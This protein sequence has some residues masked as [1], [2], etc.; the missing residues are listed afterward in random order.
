MSERSDCFVSQGQSF[1]SRKRGKF[2]LTKIQRALVAKEEK[3]ML[4][5][6]QRALVARRE[7]VLLTRKNE[8]AG[9]AKTMFGVNMLMMSG[10]ANQNQGEKKK[11][12]W[13]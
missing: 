1:G 6:K 10:G 11:E 5:K 7:K 2:L 13:E 8:K 4:T 9:A 3:S 12:N